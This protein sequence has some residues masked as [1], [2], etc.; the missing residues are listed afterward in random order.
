VAKAVVN[1]EAD[2]SSRAGDVQLSLEQLASLGIF[3][4]LKKAPTFAKFPGSYVLRR[5]RAG[6]VIC[7][8]GETGGTAFYLLTTSDIEALSKQAAADAQKTAGGMD[9]ALRRQC[10]QLLVQMRN[11]S[12]TSGGSDGASALRLATARLLLDAGPKPKPP[13]R[14]WPWSR[15]SSA[16]VMSEAAPQPLFIA[17]DGPADINYA[18]KQ[19]PMYAGEVFGEMSCLWRQPRSATVVAD[20]DC[21]VLEF[22]RNILDQ[23]RKDP[24]CK[25][26]TEQKYRE[27]VLGSHLRQL[28]IFAFLSDEEF[29]EIRQQVELVE[30]DPGSVIWDEGDEPDSLLIVRSGSVQVLQNYPWRLTVQAVSDWKALLAALGGPDPKTGAIEKL[31]KALPAAIQEKLAAA[32]DPAPD[33]LQE[34]L[35]FAMNELAKTDALLTA[36]EMQAEMST[37]EFV[38]ETSG[39]PAKVKTWSGLQIRRG[40]RVL[41]HLLFP[42][43]ISPADPRGITKVLRYVGRGETLG[44]IGLVLKQSRSAT[45]VA[46]S[47]PELDRESTAV[48]VVRV[49]AAAVAAMADRS[50][51]MRAEIEKIAALRHKSEPSVKES[52][53]SALSQ[54]RRAEELGLLQGQNLMLIDLDRCTRCGDCVEACISTHDDGFSR[55]F[56]DG[57]RFGKYLIPSSCRLCRDPVCMIGCPVGSIQQGENGEITIRE[58]CIGCGVCARQCPYDSIQMHVTA[59]IPPETSGWLWTDHADATSGKGWSE[60][61]YRDA[62]WQSGSTPFRWDIDMHQAVLAGDRPGPDRAKD[63]QLC[64]RFPF[65][66]DPAQLAADGRYRLVLTSQGGDLNAYLNGRQLELSQDA[67]QKKRGE[68]AASIAESELRR[69]E[70]LLAVSVVLPTEFNATILGARLDAMTPELADVEEK[71]VTERAVVC[72]QCSSLSGNRHA[73]VYACPHEAALRVDTWVDFPDGT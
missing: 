41:F 7:R 33:D 31:R 46:Y 66:V 55:L 29:G 63:R 32:T 72:D 21:F 51:R 49:P 61:S 68:Y 57:P 52:S 15:R 30:F 19:A 43:A 39:Y 4:S 70:N 64:F 65:R 69:G 2:L 10:E 71:L 28:S 22:L 37:A 25:K 24:D 45:C 56:L 34:S 44:E 40:N 35:I 20:A 18:T 5:F 48:E 58:W 1:P 6:E 47:H 67:P 36:K 11:A 8:Q 9:D 38:R 27:R 17:N 53:I 14:A 42:S 13:G 62:K 3:A 12:V 26:A 50:P 23:M 54:S 73:C 60:L 59:I 16:G